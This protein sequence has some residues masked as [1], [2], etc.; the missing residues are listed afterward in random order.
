MNI[1]L[2]HFSGVVIGIVCNLQYRMPPPEQAVISNSTTKFACPSPT[3]VHPCNWCKEVHVCKS[4]KHRKTCSCALCTVDDSCCFHDVRLGPKT[5][6]YHMK[7]ILVS[8]VTGCD[9]TH[10]ATTL[11]GFNKHASSRREAVSDSR[12]CIPRCTEK[13]SKNIFCSHVSIVR[14]VQSTIPVSSDSHSHLSPSELVST[15]FVPTPNI[16]LNLWN[17]SR[18]SA[19]VPISLGFTSVLTDDIVSSFRNTKS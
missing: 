18:P 11:Q 17:L 10:C 1:F 16:H 7:V 3:S 5:S 14:L 19:F 4:G 8:A 15:S 9:V 13:I 2:L 6:V 12:G